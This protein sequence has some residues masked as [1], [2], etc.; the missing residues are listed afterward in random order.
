MLV[1][2]AKLVSLTNAAAALPGVIGSAAGFQD[3]P[4]KN[5]DSSSKASRAVPAFTSS[6]SPG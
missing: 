4:P 5:P 1:A 2:P 3:E 6:A